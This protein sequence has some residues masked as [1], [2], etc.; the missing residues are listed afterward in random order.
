MKDAD[1]PPVW[2]K[3]NFLRDKRDGPESNQPVLIDWD[4]PMSSPWNK[5][6][7]SVLT[8]EYLDAIRAGE[9]PRVSTVPDQTI[10]ELV[11]I[12]SQKL[13]RVRG[14]RKKSGL[15]T[16]EALEAQD[17]ATGKAARATRRRHSVFILSYPCCEFQL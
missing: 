17:Q 3:Q 10:E 4:S 8:I 2:R 16:T 11:K 7:L 14:R 12:C 15:M 9:Y 13:D 1:F 5:E 6:T